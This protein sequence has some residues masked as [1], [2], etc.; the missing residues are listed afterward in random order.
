MNGFIIVNKPKDYTSNDV[1]VMIRGALS[2]NGYKVKVGHLGTLDPN[3]TGVLPICI[4][5]A[6]RL[7]D[8][9]LKK[10]K[11]YV[12]EFTFGKTTD[13]LDACGK[14]LFENNKISS[15]ED[16]K[17]ALI[18]MTGKYMQIPPK[19]SAK[20]INGKKAYD[21]AREG[22][23]IDLEAKEVEIYS[24]SE[25]KEI[26]QNVFSAKICCSSGTY[27]RSI[28]KDLADKM[29]TLGYMSALCRTRAGTFN[30]DEAEELNTILNTK[31]TDYVKPILPYLP[32]E[33]YDLDEKLSFKALNGIKIE[34]SDAPKGL[35]ALLIKNE[36][37]G[38]ASCDNGLK[39]L[40]RLG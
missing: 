37:I 1:V 11:E 39:I 13:T 9:F 19:Y 32:L 22:I 3:A 6:T 15:F 16:F 28:A 36:L 20:S 38:L 10:D 18:S 35:F 34:L 17:S 27:I 2:R 14:I 24:V 21:L 4:G 23:E 40:T 30:I 29:G 33:R 7:F 5:K 12:A 8:Y 26:G 31:V 25:F